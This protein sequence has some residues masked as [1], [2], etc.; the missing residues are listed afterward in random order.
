MPHKKT[1]FADPDFQ[2]MMDVIAT[3]VF[4]KDVRHRYV[5]L[6][7][8]FAD[9]L[10]VTREDLVNADGRD[11][12]KDGEFE[13]FSAKDDEVFKTG[14]MVEAEQQLTNVRGD[15]CTVINRKML[16]TF[17]GAPVLVGVIHDITAY[18][19]SEAYN[20]FL[21][22]HD[23]LTGLPN[24]AFLYERVERA[25]AESQ[26]VGANVALMMLDIDRFK[27]INDTY[28]HLAGDELIREFSQRLTAVVGGD[29]MVARLGGDEFAI[30]LSPLGAVTDVVDLCRR[31][32]DRAATPFNVIGSHAYVSASMGIAVCPGEAGL[33]VGELLR[34]ADIA[35]YQAK[36][37]G[38]GLYRFFDESM[39]DGRKR[40]TEIE[41][42]LR[43]ALETGQGLSVAYQP[44][45]KN[46]SEALIGVEALIRWNHPRLG[47]LPPV[48]F[49]SIAEESGLIFLLGDWVLQKAC[50]ALR[51]FDDLSLAVNVSA[52]QLRDPCL[53]DRVFEIVRVT[54]FDP[55]RL[56]LEITETAILNANRVAKETIRRLRERGIRIALDDFG[57][58][59]SNLDHLSQLDVD[60]IKIDRSFT[61][62][63]AQ[64][65]SAA[66]IV[67]AVTQIATALNLATTVEGV[68]TEEQRDCFSTIP[69]TELQG[70]LFSKPISADELSQFVEQYRKRVVSRSA[71][72]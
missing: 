58:G 30:F 33:T 24:R 18:R 15:T 9:L 44:I 20:R 25:L 36:V 37:R 23:T 14:G 17:N 3:P 42:D 67:T 68:E 11:I 4:V 6:N 40:R 70:F 72:T 59:Y 28:G 49:I 7:Q 34:K 45:V 8:A 38:S 69:C 13:A 46:G 21:A 71:A 26:A 16:L 66:A 60:K 29:H 64:S 22:F 47:W 32:S 35:L 2:Q 12:Y 48:Q 54:G 31:I 19:K 39:D 61:M 57:T 63:M 43:I 55:R 52:I 41:R 62:R 65:A 10:G 53:A 56:E 27:E 1:L 50:E 51:E 5:F